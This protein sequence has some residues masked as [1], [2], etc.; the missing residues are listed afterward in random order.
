MIAQKP[1]ED[2]RPGKVPHTDEQY[3]RLLKR[4][5]L[6]GRD[7]VAMRRGMIRLA[8]TICEHVWGKKFF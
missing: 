1:T 2:R 5:H 4:P 7:I 6:T 3:R 8:Q